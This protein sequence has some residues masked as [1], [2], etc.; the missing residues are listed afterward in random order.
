MPFHFNTTADGML[1]AANGFDRPLRWRHLDPEMD[2]IGVDAALTA[3]VMAGGG[4]GAIIGTYWAYVRFLDEDGNPSNLS[5]ISFAYE[6][7]GR[8]GAVSTIPGSH[9][10]TFTTGSGSVPLT[11]TSVYHGLNTGAVVTVSGVL[12]CTAANGTWLVRKESIHTFSLWISLVSGGISGTGPVGN[13]TYAGGGTWVRGSQSVSS[14]SNATPIV[15]TSASHGLTTGDMVKITGVGGNVSANNTWA[16]TVLTSSTFSL[17]GSKGSGD[18]TGG[19]TW[20]SGVD[21]I[22]YS[23]VP[24]PTQAKVVRRQI[25][26]NTAGQAQTFYVD[27]D[28][29]DLTSTT[30]TSDKVDSVL[31]TQ[32]AVPLFDADGN[33]LANRYGLP[34]N[35]K[36]VF[37]SHL[38]RMF[39]AVE[40]EYSQGMVMVTFGSLTVTGV[41][42]EWTA[43][44]DG[45]YL[46]VRGAD[47]AYQIDSVDVANQTVT[48]TEAYLGPT[49]YFG[50]YAIRPAPA[51]RRLIYWSGS[52]EPEAWPAV[53]AFSLPE[54]GDEI[55]GLMPRSSFLYVLEER[56]IYRFTFQSNPAEDGFMF[57][58]ANRGCVNN[59]CWVV[60][61]ETA[62]LLDEQGVYSFGGGQE[63]T[64][65]SYPI[66]DIFRAT[67]DPYRIQWQAKKWF[68]AC[69][70]PAQE[71]IRW[72]VT[73][74]GEDLPRHALAYSYTLQ[75]W[76]VEE[77][78][79]PIGASCVAPLD[80]Q[81]TVLGATADR[82]FALWEG[83]LDGANPDN[84]TVRG[85]VSSSTLTSFTDS[86]A[87]FPSSGVVGYAVSIVAGMGKGQQRIVRA[88]SGTTV[89]VVQ[90]WMVAPNSTS[91]YQL[92]GIPWLW[93]TGRFRWVKDEE[94]ENRRVEVCWEPTS[95]E[96]TM[97]MQVYRDFSATPR[98][99]QTTY[100]SGDGGGVASTQGSPRLVFDLTKSHGV[101][102]KAM[103]D[104][105]EYFSDGAR[106]VSVELSGV[107]NDD[108]VR[109]YEVNVEGARQ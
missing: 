95:E 23:S 71:T 101:A 47:Q 79:F 44:M 58:S 61:G 7:S 69:H 84:G 45:R 100:R 65:I 52:G 51:E 59:R 14:V 43:A 49:S 6:A 48:L 21:T 1:F 28:T 41:G 33:A 88:V 9:T 74:G 8:T 62:Y 96:C 102:S 70:Y 85:T 12:G 103:G 86:S 19:G 109:V 87:S 93:K 89:H 91:K 16:V 108:E 4:A 92:G 11:V 94:F 38:G 20:V 67:G 32:T 26:R 40:H 98:D 63:V 13:G 17:D 5:P 39:L 36:A 97:D 77:Y 78:P 3:L 107:T 25:L 55:T 42:T 30:F 27:V 15:V 81:R 37:A 24:V 50:V 2:V 54:D 29:T 106:F 90:P 46:Y 105:K 18:Y 34:P 82:C 80:H 72:F 66:S 35:H 57:H 68:H 83:T 31:S 75:R 56:N 60:V 73:M 10:I 53:N 99:W 22:L 76:W 104:R 64:N